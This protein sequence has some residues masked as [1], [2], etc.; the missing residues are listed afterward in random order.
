MDENV[1]F[2]Q[3]VGRERIQELNQILQKY[4]Y[5]KARDNYYKS[6]K[7]TLTEDKQMLNNHQIN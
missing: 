3:P 1:I 4:K 6:L 2:P 7:L 5:G